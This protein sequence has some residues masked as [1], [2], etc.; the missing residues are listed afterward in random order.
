MK[1]V[2]TPAD[3]LL[4]KKGKMEDWAVIAC[5][6]FSSEK[7]Y[8]DRVSHRVE[9]TPSTLH[10]VVPEAWL[11]EVSMEEASRERNETMAKYV[12]DDLFQTYPNTFV[13]VEREIS[14]GKIRRGVVGKLDLE[15]YDFRAGVF[16]PARA[17]EKTVIERLPPRIKVRSSACLEM[18]HVLVLIDDEGRHAVEPLTEQKSDFEVLYDFDLMEEGGH[19]TGYRLTPSATNAFVEA[20]DCLGTRDVQFVIGDGNHSLAAAK[21]IWREVKKSLSLFR[22]TKMRLSPF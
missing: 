14:G 16:P 15:A 17:S 20:I 18:P 2:F 7:E 22:L 21:E 10:M 8:W 9:K 13:Y 3:I 19:I 5:D 4:P 1:H 6:Q 11:G 12:N